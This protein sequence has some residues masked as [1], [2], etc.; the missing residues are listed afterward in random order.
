VTGG[1][2]NKT[3]VTRPKTIYGLLTGGSAPVGPIKRHTVDLSALQPD[4]DRLLKEDAES[5]PAFELPKETKAEMSTSLYTR[6]LPVY[7][8]MNK[9][10]K[11]SATSTATVKPVSTV[12]TVTPTSAA[13]KPLGSVLSESIKTGETNKPLNRITPDGA[14]KPLFFKAAR[15]GSSQELQSAV[16]PQTAVIPQGRIKLDSKYEKQASI[17][18]LPPEPKK[19]TVQP[20]VTSQQPE[21]VSVEK[22]KASTL[23]RRESLKQQYDK[24]QVRWRHPHI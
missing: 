22:P 14:P 24:L 19:E 20:A 5:K 4:P 8:R 6:P 23:A 17:E 3:G 18:V 12:A 11:P 7:S 1:V 16:A 15:S 21:T 10:V 13:P 9:T 2:T